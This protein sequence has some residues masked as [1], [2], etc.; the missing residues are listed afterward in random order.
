MTQWELW[1]QEVTLEPEGDEWEEGP[2]RGHCRCKGP[3]A[4]DRIQEE[5][6]RLRRS[7]QVR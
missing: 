6:V 5:G 3:E 2:G 7:R 4:G 1:L